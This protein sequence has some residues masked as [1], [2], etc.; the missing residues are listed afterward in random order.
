MGTVGRTASNQ[1][2]L[3]PGG[4]AARRR[5]A[6]R[7]KLHWSAAHDISGQAAIRLLGAD[8]TFKPIWPDDLKVYF[9]L[10][11]PA[12]IA[13]E[14]G[15]NALATPNTAA[16]PTGSAQSSAAAQPAAAGLLPATQ[17]ITDFAN[18]DMSIFRS[19]A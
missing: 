11:I 15:W 3:R 18:T 14:L 16:A 13:V 4:H 10:P 9:D 17:K 2:A 5:R 8:H 6:R 19:S 1:T 12:S 7:E